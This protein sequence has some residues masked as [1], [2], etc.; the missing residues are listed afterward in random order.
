MELTGTIHDKEPG[1]SPRGIVPRLFFEQT[2][3]PASP[4]N[5]SAL[6]AGALKQSLGGVRRSGSPRVCGSGLDQ[7]PLQLAK[8]RRSEDG[9]CAPWVL[10][11]WALR[12]ALGEWESRGLCSLGKRGVGGSAGHP[13]PPVEV[14]IA[15][16]VEATRF[17]VLGGL[18]GGGVSDDEEGFGG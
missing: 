2:P 7:W 8:A 17:S 6:K 4:R 13:P 9:L 16:R 5:D 18:T 14:G 11:Y 15:S 3:G 12:W 1:R 10:N